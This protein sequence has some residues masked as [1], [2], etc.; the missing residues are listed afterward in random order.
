MD[1]L[2][3]SENSQ[4]LREARMECSKQLAQLYQLQIPNRTYVKI[5]GTI[6]YL[7]LL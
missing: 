1:A 2:G 7:N 6:Q 3:C 5:F 4:N